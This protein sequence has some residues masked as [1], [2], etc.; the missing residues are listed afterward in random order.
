MVKAQCQRTGVCCSKLYAHV[1]IKISNNCLKKKNR[2]Q[3]PNTKPRIAK[4][5]IE[6]AEKAQEVGLQYFPCR[7][8][9][10]GNICTLQDKKPETC[11]LTMSKKNMLSS[12]DEYP[13]I[14]FHKKCGWLDGAPDMIKRLARI[15]EEQTEINTLTSW[16][17]YKRWWSLEY[18]RNEILNS[19]EAK[20]WYVENGKWKKREDDEK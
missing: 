16:G 13:F 1:M 2:K 3:Y 6:D 12:D 14:A 9:E 7:F 10:D 4:A 20:G 11:S 19:E 8:L 15:C 18:R 17:N 5:W